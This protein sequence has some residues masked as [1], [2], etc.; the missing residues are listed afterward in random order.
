[1]NSVCSPQGSKMQSDR[2]FFSKIWTIIC[3]NCKMVRDRIVSQLILIT[4]RKSHMGLRLV[5]TIDICDLEWLWNG[6]IALIL[7]YFTEFDSFAGRLRHSGWWYDLTVCR[8][9]SSTFGQNWPTLER[10]LSAIAELL[11]ICH[12]P[13]LH[14]AS[15]YQNCVSLKFL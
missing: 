11:V 4:N 9:L 3:G 6:I 12:N 10:G 2:F 5:Y 8:I 1:M 15:K 14:N 13:W 7:L